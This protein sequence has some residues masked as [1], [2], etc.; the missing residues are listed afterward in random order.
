MAKIFALLLIALAVSGPAVA[1]HEEVTVAW[2]IG[3]DELTDEVLLHDGRAYHASPWINFS[4]LVPGERFL[5]ELA[6]RGSHKEI[7]AM[8]PAPVM[9]GPRLTAAND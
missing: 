3:V 5:I 4:L 9:E 2:V 1:D 6:R 8:I 7:V